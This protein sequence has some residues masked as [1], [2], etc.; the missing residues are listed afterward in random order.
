ML[1]GLIVSEVLAALRA[2]AG[3]S[4]FE[5]AVEGMPA[6]VVEADEQRSDRCRLH[7]LSGLD[8]PIAAGILALAPVAGAPRMWGHSSAGRALGWQPRGQGFDPPWLHQ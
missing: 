4:S 2:G 7:G 3:E 6:P 8:R 5:P 1:G